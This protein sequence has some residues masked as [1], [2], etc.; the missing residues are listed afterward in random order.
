MKTTDCVKSGRSFSYT[1]PTIHRVG[2]FRNFRNYTA[3]VKVCIIV[4]GLRCGLSQCVYL[5]GF[6]GLVVLSR[7]RELLTHPGN[8]YL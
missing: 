2:I 3:K 8:L 5:S 7:V 4:Q 1:N 6:R